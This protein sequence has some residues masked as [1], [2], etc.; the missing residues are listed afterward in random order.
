VKASHRWLELAGPAYVPD[1]P[2]HGYAILKHYTA[3][4]MEWGEGPPLI[5]LPGLAGGVGL[6]TPLAASLARYFRVISY[7]LRGEGDCFALRRRFSVADLVADL[8]EILDLWRVERPTLMGVSFGGLIAAEYA[9][10]FPHHVD[11]LVLQGV[12]VRFAPTLLR[13]VAGQIL[14]D[15]PLPTDSPFVNQF[16]NLLFGSRPKNRLLFEFVTQQCWQTDQSVI[17]HRFRLAERTDLAPKLNRIVAPTLLFTGE[18]DLLVSV[19]GSRE[20]EQGLANVRHEIL[21]GA[22]HLAFVTHA[23]ELARATYT[24]AAREPKLIP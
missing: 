6:V 4:Y 20:L 3:E 13:R 5:L 7:Q 16:F 10:R 1:V 2:R 23:A 21:L 17:A 9:A 22:G 14:R 11:R 12:D 8:G 19:Q 24:F 15:Y 18:N